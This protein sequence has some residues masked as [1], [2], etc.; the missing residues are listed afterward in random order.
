MIVFR[1]C[2]PR[3]LP[4]KNEITCTH[5]VHAFIYNSQKWEKFR[6]PSITEEW[7]NC[8]IFIW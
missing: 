2:I 6:C 3:N 4:K 5:E 1:N 8:D 7:I